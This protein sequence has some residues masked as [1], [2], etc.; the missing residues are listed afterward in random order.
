MKGTLFGAEGRFWKETQK[1]IAFLSGY[2]VWMTFLKLFAFSVLSSLRI[3]GSTE[4]AS[5][6]PDI[7]PETWDNSGL[8]NS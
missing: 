3:N 7:L 5:Q 6:S 4:R 2:C 1:E 8:P